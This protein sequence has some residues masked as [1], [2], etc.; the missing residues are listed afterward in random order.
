[1][2][3][4]YQF[5][6]KPPWRRSNNTRAIFH[7]TLFSVVTRFLPYH[8][9]RI[10]N[11]ANVIR[12]CISVKRKTID[13][14]LENA[15]ANHSPF[16]IS[17]IEFIHKTQYGLPRKYCCVKWVRFHSGIRSTV[18]TG[19]NNV[20][21]LANIT[22]ACVL[23]ANF[24]NLKERRCLKTF[25]DQIAELSFGENMLYPLQLHTR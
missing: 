19:D 21:R 2:L 25:I 11:I 18:I 9:C 14:T 20:N 22:F 13:R 16:S 12:V 7:I 15:L 23:K 17:K 8:Q 10:S 5:V 24:E 1:M 4:R 6:A 3:V